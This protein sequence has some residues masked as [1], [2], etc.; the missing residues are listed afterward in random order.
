[1]RDNELRMTEM[2]NGLV[3]AGVKCDDAVVIDA[4]GFVVSEAGGGGMRR[5]TGARSTF[6]HDEIAQLAYSF[7]ESRGHQDGYAVEDWLRAEQQLIH[8]YA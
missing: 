4:A 5:Y 2:P 3:I 7:Y 8:H 6:T 1:M